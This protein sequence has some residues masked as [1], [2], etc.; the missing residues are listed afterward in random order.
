MHTLLKISM[1]ASL[2]FAVSRRDQPG[3][4][5][6]ETVNFSNLQAP[7]TMPYVAPGKSK[8]YFIYGPWMDFVDMVLV[9]G[10]PQRIVEKKAL[11]NSD[12]G[13]LRVMLTVPPGTG[14]GQ[15][16][17]TL[18]INCPP[19]PL[20]DCVTKNVARKVMVLRVGTTVQITPSANVAMGQPSAFTITGTGLDVASIFAFR[21]MLSNTSAPVR[22]AGTFQVT[23]TPTSCGTNVVM[24]RDQAEGGDFYPYQAALSVAT[25]STCGTQPT[26]PVLKSCP[27]GT[28]YDAVTKTCLKGEEAAGQH[29][30]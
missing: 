26:P 14:R 1:A 29:G 11:F 9:A 3:V 24:L 20:T 25:T 13:L 23:G 17:L 22:T 8:E 5:R 16:D 27:M 10:V 2:V 4:K 28:S 19:I 12:G 7:V 21:T 6:I 30:R 18:H 15:E